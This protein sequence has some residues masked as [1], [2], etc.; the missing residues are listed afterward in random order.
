MEVDVA[1]VRELRTFV[2]I[3]FQGDDRQVLQLGNHMT[4]TF[5]GQ[6][7]ASAAVVRRRDKRLGG[8]KDPLGS[9]SKRTKAGV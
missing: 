5:W 9:E 4:V 2:R 3:T 8:L 1:R 6:Q 7:A